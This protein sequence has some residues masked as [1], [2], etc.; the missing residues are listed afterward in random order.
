MFL[1]GVALIGIS[2]LVSFL[3]T[4]LI[5][6]YNHKIV[7]LVLLGGFLFIAVYLPLFFGVSPVNNSDRGA[8]LQETAA[9]IGFP[10]TKL[11]VANNFPLFG[12]VSGFGKT[13]TVTIDRHIY[14]SYSL[15]EVQGVVVHELAHTRYYDHFL[16]TLLI[17]IAFFMNAYFWNKN[18]LIVK[19][20][21][22]FVLAMLSTVFCLFLVLFVLRYSEY[23]ADRFAL[24]NLESP[25][26]RVNYFEHLATEGKVPSYEESKSYPA[27][28]ELFVTHPPMHKRIDLAKQY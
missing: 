19:N 20:P 18:K 8:S 22:K 2:F 15:V 28:L 1:E 25:Q 21:R 14:E 9:T 13:K 27:W 16:Y 5:K 7:F 4:L 10:S 17:P 6:R 11:L 26:A 12:Y 24:V 23:R 3:L